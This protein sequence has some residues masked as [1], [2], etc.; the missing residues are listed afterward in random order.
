MLPWFPSPGARQ[1]GTV[2]QVQPRPYQPSGTRS[3]TAPA[4]MTQ[5]AMENE[6]VHSE[7]GASPRGSQQQRIVLVYRVKAA[8]AAGKRVREDRFSP[9]DLAQDQALS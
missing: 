5:G 7:F 6:C 2:I 1:T 8:K 3:T 9:N 4:T